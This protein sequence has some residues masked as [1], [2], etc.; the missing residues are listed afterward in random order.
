MGM[1]EYK[2]QDTTNMN[3]SVSTGD[4][5]VSA[6]AKSVSAGAQYAK[7]PG[8][9]KRF[10]SAFIFFSSE[11]HPQIRSQ[12]GEKGAKEKVSRAYCLL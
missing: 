8:A 5:S 10:K 3:K 7:A 6:G 1:N 12:L 4:K 9:P 2:L 11:K